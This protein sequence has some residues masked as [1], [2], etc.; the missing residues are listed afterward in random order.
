VVEDRVTGAAAIATSPA[1]Y[2]YFVA[3]ESYKIPSEIM[4]VTVIGTIAGNTDKITS[5]VNL[6]QW[7]SRLVSLA[8]PV[9]QY[10]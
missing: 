8:S 1:L 6:L 2:S 4:S 9:K 5:N 10:T 3:S 7:A